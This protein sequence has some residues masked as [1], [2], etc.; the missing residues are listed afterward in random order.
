MG[1]PEMSFKCGA[2]EA[3]IFEND[4][5]RNGQTV[6]IKKTVFQKRYKGQ[7]GQWQSTSSLDVNDIPKA[8]LAL[9]QAYKYL[10]SARHESNGTQEQA[11]NPGG[12]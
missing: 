10:V 4:I 9:S 7:D 3:A 2:C 8:I 12:E 5:N 11:I 1:K 6:K